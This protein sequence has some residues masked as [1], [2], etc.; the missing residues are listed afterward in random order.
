MQAFSYLAKYLIGYKEL[1]LFSIFPTTNF[2]TKLKMHHCEMTLFTFLN[3]NCNWF[4][5]EQLEQMN[6]NF[7]KFEP[8][9]TLFI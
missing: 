8:V 3:C 2:V 4:K 9:H 5:S 6:N 7:L 1:Q